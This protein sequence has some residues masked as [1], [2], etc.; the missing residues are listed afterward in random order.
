[1]GPLLFVH[2]MEQ[3]GHGRPELIAVDIAEHRGDVPSFQSAT[4]LLEHRRTFL[5]EDVAEFPWGMATDATEFADEES[6]AE[7]LIGKR[8]AGGRKAFVTGDSRSSCDLVG[9][10]G[11]E[12]DISIA[13]RIAVVLEIQRSV[14]G[15]FIDGGCRCGTWNVLVAVDWK[16]VEPY[17]QF[18]IGD[19]LPVAIPACC[20][21]FDVV[22]LPLQ[23]GQ[24][25]VEVGGF[26]AVDRAA[27]VSFIVEPEGIEDLGFVSPLVI[28]TAVAASLP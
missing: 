14:A 20:G 2:S 26:Y 1:M 22:G 21:E 16:T 13:D 6:P 10:Q 27:S 3:V 5:F 23:W 11:N 4:D 18:R 8:A 19:F 7:L 15:V 9:I 17:A 24:A 12:P 28:H 25:C